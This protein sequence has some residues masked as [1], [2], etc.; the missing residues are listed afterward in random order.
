MIEVVDQEVKMVITVFEYLRGNMNLI[1][2]EMKD[3]NE[4]NI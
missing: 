4:W 2:S 3:V 1:R